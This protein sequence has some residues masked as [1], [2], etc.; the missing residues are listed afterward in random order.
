MCGDGPGR[1]PLQPLPT[2]VVVLLAA[3]TSGRW[4]PSAVAGPDRG[5]TACSHLFKRM[6]MELRHRAR[7]TLQHAQAA[8][9]RAA[10]APP[11][12][13]E[14]ARWQG[15]LEG[16]A[17]LVRKELLAAQADGLLPDGAQSVETAVLCL[18]SRLVPDH[19]TARKVDV[20][21]MME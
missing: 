11:G 2:I 5:L 7:D 15:W 12:T 3:C 9:S 13:P 21:I 18:G 14:Q 10:Q 4:A 1:G 6:P 8:R 19:Y 16:N 17:S 20:T